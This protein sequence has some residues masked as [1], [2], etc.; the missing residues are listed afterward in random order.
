VSLV[1]TWEELNPRPKLAS[2]LAS[3]QTLLFDL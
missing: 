2:V 1:S 3:V